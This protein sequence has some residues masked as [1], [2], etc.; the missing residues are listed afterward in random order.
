MHYAAISSLESLFHQPAIN[1]EY[2]IKPFSMPI[3][4]DENLLHAALIA[5]HNRSG[6]YFNTAYPKK[7]IVLHYTAGQLRSDIQ[8]L[9][10]NN[11][12][13]S[14]A[15]VIARD[16]RIYQLFSSKYWSGHIGKGIGN[17][18]TGNME[19]K[20]TIGIEL[21][22]Y[23]WLTRRGDNLETCYSRSIASNGNVTGQD[24][25]CHISEKQAY[26]ELEVPFRGK[27]YFAKFTD[28]Q[29]NSL[30]ILLRYLTATYGIARKF[31]DES[32][33]YTAFNDVVSFNGIVSHVNY[34]ESGKWDIGPAFDWNRV[35]SGVQADSYTDLFPPGG[36]RGGELITEEEDSFF[37]EPAPA[38]EED[39]PY[40]EITRN[41]EAYIGDGD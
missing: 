35:I 22:N 41:P 20:M 1:R 4:D 8:A 2:R 25:Y 36:M 29:Y 24:V 3:L 17:T 32:V 10:Q 12:H 5:P 14:V 6:Y 16:G 31:P 15:F 34:R 30:I 13:V 9:T 18:G 19:D 40:E 23:G 27:K 28:E 11:Y 21:S 7:R 37:P 33:R 38:A 39:Q 26:T